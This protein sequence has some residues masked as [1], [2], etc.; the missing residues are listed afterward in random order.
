M[1]TIG[2]RIGAGAIA[3]T[4][5]ASTAAP[6]AASAATPG[7]RIVST[8]SRPGI[9]DELA[10]IALSGT[11]AWA[12]GNVAPSHS[13][14][15]VPFV[16]HW[17]GHHWRARRLPAG[18]AGALEDLS[19]SAWTTYGRSARTSMALAASRFVLTVTSGV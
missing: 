13:S 19:A 3:A 16:E 8:D 1:L 6:A 2:R 4:M 10:V 14:I 9:D 17:N 12:G 11:N 5:L 15:G 18:P 7:W